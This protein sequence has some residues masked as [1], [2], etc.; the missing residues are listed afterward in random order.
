MSQNDRKRPPVP[1]PSPM[2]AVQTERGQME[3][4]KQKKKKKTSRGK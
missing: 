3:S 1:P 2:G 4:L